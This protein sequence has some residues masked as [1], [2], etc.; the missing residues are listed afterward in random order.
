MK[1]ASRDTAA[2]FFSALGSCALAVLGFALFH[3]PCPE[4]VP[5][6]PA[7]ECVGSMPFQEFV[8]WCGG[9]AIVLGIVA[10]LISESIPDK[11]YQ[12]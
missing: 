9:A 5:G 7:G 6:V 12:P 11:P 8:T 3:T 10:A 1:H 4:I 2:F